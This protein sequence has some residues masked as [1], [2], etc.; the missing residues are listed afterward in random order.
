[1]ESII[2]GIKTRYTQQNIAD[3]SQDDLEAEVMNE[4]RNNKSFKEVQYEEVPN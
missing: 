1:M 3:M 2:N 4:M